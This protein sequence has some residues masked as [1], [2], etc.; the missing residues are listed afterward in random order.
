MKSE[1]PSQDQWILPIILLATI[2]FFNFLSRVILGPLLPVI[3]VDFRLNHHDAGYL[4]LILSIGYCLAIFLSGYASAKWNH[5]WTIVISTLAVGLSLLFASM[6]RSFLELASGLFFIGAATG[7][8]LPSGIASITSLAPAR[9]WGKALAIH[10]LAPNLGFVAAPLYAEA[11]L[12]CSNWRGAFLAIGVVSL[13]AGAIFSFRGKGGDFHGESPN[14]KN[15]SLLLHDP[16]F[17]A[18]TL[19]FGLVIG[20]SMG[21]FVMLPLYLTDERGMGRSW[22][23]TLIAVSRL[24]GAFIVFFSG[25]I[26]DHLGAKRTMAIVIVA[27]GLLTVFLGLAEENLLVPIV[28]LQPLLVVCFFPAAFAALSNIGPEKS[29]NVA[30][31]LAILIAYPI[32]AGLIPAV[33]GAVGEIS[34][35]SLAISITGIL[36]TLSAALLRFL[37]TAPAHIVPS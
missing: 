11:V 20:A 27:S 22:A 23:N 31:S 26:S 18:M 8:Y 5:R 10:E 37:K 4:F 33:I 21:I 9:S 2:F 3:E 1:T 6:S 19:L 35:F 32:G 13:L 14:L 7:L 25:W 15:I 28:F 16:A 36:I 12:S 17:W 34:S 29:R 30:V 24:S